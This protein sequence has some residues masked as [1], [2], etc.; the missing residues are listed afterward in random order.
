[1]GRQEVLGLT[2]LVN[3]ALGKPVAAILGLLHITPENPAYPI[4]NAVA[5]ELLVVLVAV[6]F[7]LWLKARIRADRPG[8]TQ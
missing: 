7:F 1:M 8:E 3:A 4:P 6:L 2:K 5:M